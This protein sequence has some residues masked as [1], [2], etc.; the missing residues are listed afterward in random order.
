VKDLDD[1]MP[2]WM[3]SMER[4]TA[5]ARSLAS[6]PARCSAWSRKRSRKK[7]PAGGLVRKDP[8]DLVPEWMVSPERVSDDACAP[9]PVAVFVPSSRHQSLV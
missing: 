7:A 6:A 5:R 8:D 2:E 3:V 4:A 9:T 1:L